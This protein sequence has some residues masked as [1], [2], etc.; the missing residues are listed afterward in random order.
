VVD[1]EFG[2]NG[3]FRIAEIEKEFHMA[4]GEQTFIEVTD[5]T[6]MC[7][8]APYLL[9]TSE[10]ALYDSYIG[11]D[12]YGKLVH[13]PDTAALTAWL[14]KTQTYFDSFVRLDTEIW[15]IIKFGE[16]S[17]ATATTESGLPACKLY[18]EEDN[19]Y[20]SIKSKTAFWG[21]TKWRITFKA[22]AST[23]SLIELKFG[24][25]AITPDL[26]YLWLRFNNGTLY[27]ESY[28]DGGLKQE[29]LGSLDMTSYRRLQI[30][31][32]S[33]SSLKFYVDD[34]FKKEITQNISTSDMGHFSSLRALEDATKTCYIRSITAQELI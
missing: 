4:S 6:K 1:D 24:L 30:E 10:K 32:L 7:I 19:H 14:L 28:G 18:V 33:S 3:N 2:V 15:N 27:A 16:N 17:Y 34:V 29:N 12:N 11:V 25:D 9:R 26:D 21:N 31:R 8:N 5:L 22:K 20:A 13:F 23:N